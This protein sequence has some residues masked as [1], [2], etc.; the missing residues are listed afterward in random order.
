[1][2]ES[3]KGARATAATMAA[4][5]LAYSLVYPLGVLLPLLVVALA[6]R[7]S[8]VSYVGEVVTRGYGALSGTPIVNM[9]ACV[10]HDLPETA[11]QLR[12]SH[13]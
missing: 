1:M 4:P 7:V 6:E 3:L 5:V 9:T 11:H 12:H 13:D 8:G 2:V 10:D